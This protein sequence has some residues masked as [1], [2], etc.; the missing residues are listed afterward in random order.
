MEPEYDLWGCLVHPPQLQHIS[1]MA[2]G[3]TNLTHVDIQGE[4]GGDP[5]VQQQQGPVQETWGE[6]R[7]EEIVHAPQQGDVDLA[8]PSTQCW[9]H[10]DSAN[11]MHNGRADTKIQHLPPRLLGGTWHPIYKELPCARR[12][13]YQRISRYGLPPCTMQEPSCLQLQRGKDFV[14]QQRRSMQQGQRKRRWCRSS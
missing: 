1:H 5:G 14:K 3:H 7:W 8:T 4:P 2:R 10:Q 9:M 6:S 12:N 11:T 13:S